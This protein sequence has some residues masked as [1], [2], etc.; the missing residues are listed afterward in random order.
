MG[1]VNEQAE[2]TFAYKLK[3][4]EELKELEGF[5]INELKEV[6]FQAQI[7]YCKLDGSKCIRIISRILQTTQDES[8]AKEETNL[9]IVAVNAAHQAS[10]LTRQGKFREAQAVLMNNK[11]FIRENIKSEIDQN[12]YNNWTGEVEGLYT[13]IQEQVNKEEEAGEGLNKDQK[14][15]KKKRGEAQAVL[16]NNKKFIRENIKSEIDQNIYNNWTGEVEG[17]YTQIQ[18]QVN[19]EEEAGEGL[20]KDQ[21]EKKKKRGEAQAVLMN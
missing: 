8:Q 16:M 14:E 4:A 3:D 6:P 7:E 20:N 5:D 10:T 1:N 13:Q 17:L 2:V 18:E 15:K 21:K 11:K 9:G 19:K 12:I